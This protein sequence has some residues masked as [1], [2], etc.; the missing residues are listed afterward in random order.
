MWE[1][2]HI[3]FT[4]EKYWFVEDLTHRRVPLLLIH[5]YRGL[6]KERTHMFETD[7]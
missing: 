5:G 4:G 2:V 3:V 7:E 6:K 1:Y